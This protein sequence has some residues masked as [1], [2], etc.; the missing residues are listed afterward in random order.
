[1][2]ALVLSSIGGQLFPTISRY[3]A[4]NAYTLGHG[5]NVVNVI[6]VD[7]RGIDTLG[8]ITVLGISAIGVF[9]LLKLRE[10]KEIKEA[11]K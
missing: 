8:E 10:K 4:E 11:G 3:F 2:T 7:F 1:M 6:L 9:A 5:R